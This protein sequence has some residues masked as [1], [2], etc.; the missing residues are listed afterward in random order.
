MPG[1]GGSKSSRL[2][3]EMLHPDCHRS[4]QLKSFIL[5]GQCDGKEGLGVKP[6]LGGA[7]ALHGAHTRVSSTFRADPGPPPSDSAS[8]PT[9][10]QNKHRHPTTH[11]GPRPRATRRQTRRMCVSCGVGG[12]A[13]ERGRPA[14]LRFLPPLA[15]QRAGTQPKH[16][17]S[18]AGRCCC[19]VLVSRCTDM[20]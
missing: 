16:H 17:G 2:T 15:H 7:S 12:F 1:G 14:W 5:Q 11:G 18:R 20:V 19:S 13:T 10:P 4:K 3:L 6:G 8:R 9:A